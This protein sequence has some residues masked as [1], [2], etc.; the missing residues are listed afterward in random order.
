MTSTLI[1]P[2][3]PVERPTPAP[4]LAYR[5]ALDGLRGR[6]RHE[7]E[8][9]VEVLRDEAFVAGVQDVDVVLTNPPFGKKSSVTLATREAL[10]FGPSET[11]GGPSVVA[12]ETPPDETGSS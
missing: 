4:V 9:H 6:A 2:T 12:D 5:P 10:F 3:A 11:H 8:R 1:R 7:V